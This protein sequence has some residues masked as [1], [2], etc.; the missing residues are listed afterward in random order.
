MM[1]CHKLQG[2]F[3]KPITVDTN[4]PAHAQV[5]LTCKGKILEAVKLTPGTVNFGRIPLGEEHVE[6]KIRLSRG[7]AG[8]LKP[9]IASGT[10]EHIEA[11]LKEI[12]AGEQ[13]ELVVRACPDPK[14]QRLQGKLVL[15]T[16]VSEQETVDVN[17]YGTVTPRLAA[18]PPTVVIPSG[19]DTTW[20]QAI[21]V[22]WA[23]G[24]N[25][26]KIVN[27]SV[28]HPNLAV[29]VDAQAPRPRILLKLAHALEGSLP[30]DTQIM[31]TTDDPHGGE[32]AIP[33]RHRKPVRPPAAPGVPAVPPATGSPNSLRRKPDPPAAA[34]EANPAPSAAP[35][36]SPDPH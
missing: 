12:E 8:P 18:R 10:D 19:A 7:D 28:N 16:G 31:V 27:A 33:V 30:V 15:R 29:S 13:Y 21:E 26:Y 11:E 23:D 17:V 3:S 2:D 20:E 36:P 35:A 25:G 24:T 4:D 32:I 5:T 22:E 6:Q 14:T 34:G 9:E 1:N